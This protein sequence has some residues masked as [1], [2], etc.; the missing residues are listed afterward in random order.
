MPADSSAG[1][2]CMRVAQADAARGSA[3]TIA[4]R[5]ARGAFGMHLVD[6]EHARSRARSARAAGT[7]TG[8]RRRGRGPGPAISLPSS[9]TPPSVGGS[10]AR[11]RSTAPSTC[12]SRSG[13]S[14]RRTRPRRSSRSKSLH[15]DRLAA[16]GRRVRLRQVRDLEVLARSSCGA[17]S[18]ASASDAAR[19]DAGAALARAGRA[20]GPRSEQVL[21]DLAARPRLNARRRGSAP[22]GRA[23]AG[24]RPR[25]AGPSVAR[26]ARA[27][28]GMIRSA[29]RIAS[30]TSLVISTTVLLVSLARCARS[31]PAAW[32]A[33]A[34]RARR[35]GSSS[36]STSG[37]IASARATRD[38]LAH[39]AGQLA[40]AACRAPASG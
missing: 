16:V 31:R 40:P 39:A 35:S 36:S 33:S 13:R 5:S 7:A 26:R 18:A 17:I 8:T 29:S 27:D 25:P 4:A 3:S 19:G 14:G 37:S 22:C 11:R 12:R 2:L 28:S 20:V 9:M 32:R 21:D 10:Q 34:R 6:A 24:C 15:D 30:S 38:A 1:C 23:A